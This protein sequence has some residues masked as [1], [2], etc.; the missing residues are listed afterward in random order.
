M[1]KRTSRNFKVPLV[2]GGQWKDHQSFQKWDPISKRLVT[3]NCCLPKPCF[4]PATPTNVRLTNILDS[5]VVIS[6]DYAPNDPYEEEIF[7]VNIYHSAF[8]PVDITSNP[9]YSSSGTVQ[10]GDTILINTISTW[11]YAAT[12]SVRNRCL[13]SDDGISPSIQ[14]IFT[15]YNFR[16]NSVRGETSTDDPGAG[17]INIFDETFA[18]PLYAGLSVSVTDNIGQNMI[19]FLNSLAGA[20]AIKIQKDIDNFQIL[21]RRPNFEDYGTFWYFGCI[22]GP[23]QGTLS[24]DDIVNITY[25]NF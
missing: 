5:S 9:I 15:G 6:W 8:D 12:V 1:I 24:V 21:Y 13:F 4:K 16:I 11:Y 23:I 19:G 17:S 3:V 2:T 18:G 10:S 22:Y 25:G 14:Y 7:Q 20:S